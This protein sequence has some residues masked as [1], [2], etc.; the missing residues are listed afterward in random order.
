MV[1]DGQEQTRRLVPRPTVHAAEL[2]AA[3]PLGL[4]L[5]G[6]AAGAAFLVATARGPRTVQI[7]SITPVGPAAPM[8]PANAAMSRP[9]ALPPGIPARYI[10][11][12]R[13]TRYH[14][15]ACRRARRIAAHN[16]V[17]F[18]DSAHAAAA[19]LQPCSECVRS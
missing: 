16:R 7:L 9:G 12:S 19:G 5:L 17:G 2:S 18:A 11:S 15:P 8:T 6:K 1:I 14:L 10:A 13:G 3:S 4:A